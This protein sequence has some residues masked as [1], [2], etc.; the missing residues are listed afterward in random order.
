MG[1]GGPQQQRRRRDSIRPI[2]L[3]VPLGLKKSDI[4]AKF[5]FSVNSLVGVGGISTRFGLQRE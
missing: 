1:G 5:V 4:N 3:T 2:R